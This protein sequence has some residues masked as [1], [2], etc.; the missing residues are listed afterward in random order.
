MIDQ[1]AN[2]RVMCTLIRCATVLG[3]VFYGEPNLMSA[4]IGWLL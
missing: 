4:I 1:L 2:A 3:I